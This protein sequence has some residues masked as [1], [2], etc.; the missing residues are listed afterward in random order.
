M[1]NAIRVIADGLVASL[2]AWAAGPA[3][4][5]P[6]T[7]DQLTCQKTIQ[8]SMVKYINA[9][10]KSIAGMVESSQAGKTDKGTLQKNV[11]L[12][13]TN[14]GKQCSY[15]NGICKARLT[16]CNS[17][18]DCFG[19]C[20][21]DKTL[22]ST[23]GDCGGAQC[24]ADV[25]LTIKQCNPGVC[26]AGTK[27]NGPCDL[28]KDCGTGG[29]CNLGAIT[30]DDNEC[31]PWLNK[32]KLSDKVAAAYKDLVKSI[33]KKCADA[34]KFNA[35]L[36]DL[37]AMGLTTM[38]DCQIG[39][40]TAANPGNPC[41]DNTYTNS[42]SCTNSGACD[43]FGSG[44]GY[45]WV[46]NLAACA[47]KSLEGDIASGGG[48]VD[49]LIRPFAKMTGTQ[50]TAPTAKAGIAITDARGLLQLNGSQA[51]LIG[52]GLQEANPSSIGA[53]QQLAL[54]HCTAVDPGNSFS[55]G[56]PACLNEKDCGCKGTAGT[57]CQNND[58]VCVMSSIVPPTTGCSVNADCENLIVHDAFCDSGTCKPRSCSSDTD[59][60][61]DGGPGEKDHCGT[62]VTG[63]QN[64]HK[65]CSSV[66][67]KPSC[68]T[69]GDCSSGNCDY[70]GCRGNLLNIEETVSTVGA[71]CLYTFNQQ[72]TNNDTS[73]AGAI[74]LLTGD[75]LVQSPIQ[76]DVYFTA[77]GRCINPLAKTGVCDNNN[78]TPCL[79]YDG[80]IDQACSPADATSPT[81]LTSTIP[82]PFILST[83]LLTLTPAPG[84]EGNNYFC[85]F[86]DADHSIGC[87]TNADCPSA[88]CDF[89]GAHE[90]PGFAA[91]A[92]VTQITIT[93]EAHQYAPIM[94]GTFCTGVTDNGLIDGSSGLPGPVR[95]TQP[96][97][98]I[99]LFSSDK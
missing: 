23:N 53:V 92:S 40:C 84:Q 71:V 38:D 72:A 89:S 10:Q 55:N 11:C 97:A 8:E 78:D 58:K 76:T 49:T 86:C 51:L 96:Y 88:A 39:K 33:G 15:N 6:L 70:D 1:K 36:S 48:L 57:C 27:L 56:Q 19:S 77:C 68:A 16:P 44:L 52:T 18:S 24:V 9:V 87:Q 50:G 62:Y 79:A 45:D 21:T 29:V 3:S 67:G 98:N 80:Q 83:G 91:D 4:A 31:Q 28:D 85:G 26:S 41:N 17:N 2:L 59:C 5:A 37:Q 75:A 14:F 20:K 30:L 54:A 65:C 64:V 34:A 7:A 63:W 60:P 90:A 73:A 61:Y 69:D 25:C 81:A 99:Y 47:T 94:V 22:C 82:N 66:A 12:T 93:G 32:A 35:S 46:Y 95:I 42:D 74:D 43:Y 13:G